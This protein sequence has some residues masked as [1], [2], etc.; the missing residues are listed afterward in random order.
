[1]VACPKRST[2]SRLVLTTQSSTE[3]CLPVPARAASAD[4]QPLP[5]SH[6]RR[7]PCRRRIRRDPRRGRPTPNPAQGWARVGGAGVLRSHGPL[8][9]GAPPPPKSACGGFRR[10][11]RRRGQ[12]LPRPPGDVPRVAAEAE[13]TGSGG[14]VPG[15]CVRTVVGLPR[16]SSSLLTAA[17]AGRLADHGAGGAGAAGGFPCWRGGGPAGG[18]IP[19]GGSAGPPR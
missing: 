7:R 16:R 8:A 3:V 11:C 2:V 15:R 1:M 18:A 4:T 5:P 6:H 14:S 13:D 12:R 10:R 17:A 19:G 9:A